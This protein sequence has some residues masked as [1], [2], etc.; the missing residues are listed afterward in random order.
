MKHRTDDIL[1]KRRRELRKSMTEAEKI[2]WDELRDRRFIDFKFR[3]QHPIFGRFIIDF[4]C[5]E[6]RLAIELDGSVHEGREAI[7]KDRQNL[8]EANGIKVIRFKNEEILY[9]LNVFLEKIKEALGETP[10]P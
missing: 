7:D 5:P 9:N 4:Y 6:K 3:R 10:S 2:L 8:I 1:K